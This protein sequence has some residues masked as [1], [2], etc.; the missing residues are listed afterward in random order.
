MRLFALVIQ[1]R[2]DPDT[3]VFLPLAGALQTKFNLQSGFNDRL[4]VAG[5]ESSGIRRASTPQ[6]Q[7]DASLGSSF[8]TSVYLIRIRSLCS[9]IFSGSVRRL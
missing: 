8:E 7:D 2:N 3:T 9:G 4:E 1:V 6:K 5:F